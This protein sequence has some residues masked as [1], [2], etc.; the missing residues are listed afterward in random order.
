MRRFLSIC[1]ACLMTVALSAQQTRKLTLK[2]SPKPICDFSVYVDNPETNQRVLQFDDRSLRYVGQSLDIPVGYK[3]RISTRDVDYFL[4][5]NTWTLKEVVGNVAFTSTPN[6][7]NAEFVMPAD[8]LTLTYVFEF[9]PQN[10]Q[11]PNTNG[12]YPETGQVVI[13]SPTDNGLGSDMAKVCNFPDNDW[14]DQ[15]HGITVIGALS[16]ASYIGTWGIKGSSDISSDTA[17]V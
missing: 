3:V 10:P 6:R 12:W 15:V 16:R 1:I 2:V 7:D 5:Y 8:D 14:Y 13:D 9:N 17:V 4:Y 11:N